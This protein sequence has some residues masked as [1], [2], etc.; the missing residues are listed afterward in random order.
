MLD[1]RVINT[2]LA[3]CSMNVCKVYEI[4][5]LRKYIGIMLETFT[6]NFF[7]EKQVTILEATWQP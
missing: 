4:M 2:T 6:N 1:V 3:I 7:K 5:V